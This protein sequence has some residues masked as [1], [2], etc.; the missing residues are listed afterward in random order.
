[1][2]KLIVAHQIHFD[3]P[4]PRPKGKQGVTVRKLP[5]SPNGDGARLTMVSGVMLRAPYVDV[6]VHSGHVAAFVGWRLYVDV[7]GAMLIDG[8]PLTKVFTECWRNMRP[9]REGA[10]QVVVLTPRDP[11]HVEVAVGVEWTGKGKPRRLP[12]DL[13]LAVCGVD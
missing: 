6:R 10:E 7:D 4:V 12:A 13:T 9:V 2:S 11:A 8:A 5:V 1:M 3:V